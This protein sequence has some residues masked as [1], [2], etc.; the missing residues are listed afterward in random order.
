MNVK[1]TVGFAIAMPTSSHQILL[2]LHLSNHNA[3]GS[4]CSCQRCTCRCGNTYFHV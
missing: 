3:T 1:S 4:H 2:S